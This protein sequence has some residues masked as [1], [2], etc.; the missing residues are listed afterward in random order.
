MSQVYEI[1]SFDNRL[2]RIVHA[3][4]FLRCFAS[5][6]RH[7]KVSSGNWIEDPPPHEPIVAEGNQLG[8]LHDKMDLF[9]F[10]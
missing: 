10:I 3:P 7:M 1:V 6:R 5:D 9:G 8:H 4:M 2:F